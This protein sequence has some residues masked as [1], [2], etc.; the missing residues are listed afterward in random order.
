MDMEVEYK[1]SA[2]T[3]SHVANGV[4][5]KRIFITTDAKPTGELV[6]LPTVPLYH[7]TTIP[8]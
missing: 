7:F 4:A 6:I 3:Y 5:M 1:S 2:T 8:R